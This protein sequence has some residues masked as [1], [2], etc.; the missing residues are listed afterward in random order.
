MLVGCGSPER[1]NCAHLRACAEA[2]RDA[3]DTASTDLAR[4]DE[5]GA[6]WSDPL[7]AEACRTQ[8][9]DTMRGYDA[10]LTDAQLD[11]EICDVVVE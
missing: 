9:T 4:Y 1:G 3:F 8:C 10:V 6:C 5:N 11:A 7:V 2:Y